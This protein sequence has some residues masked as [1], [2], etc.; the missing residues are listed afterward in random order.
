[1]LPT[2]KWSARNASVSSSQASGV[3]TEAWG[4]ARVE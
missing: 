1:M 3:E 4:N 2:V